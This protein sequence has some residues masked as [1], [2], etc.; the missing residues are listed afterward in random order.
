MR[1][2]SGVDECLRVLRPH[3]SQSNVA[4]SVPSYA[5][6]YLVPLNASEEAA[7][8]HQERCGYWETS[9]TREGVKA[10]AR[11]EPP[12]AP[13]P[14]ESTTSQPTDEIGTAPPFMVSSQLNRLA[15]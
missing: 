3:S 9:F 5:S 12:P 8:S 7:T 14:S 1:P 10:I 15:V 4:G 2:P 13:L 6:D 11:G